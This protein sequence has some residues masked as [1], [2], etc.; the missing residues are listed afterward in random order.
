[1]KEAEGV[2]LKNNTPWLSPGTQTIGIAHL[3]KLI[4]SFYTDSFAGTNIGKEL[5]LTDII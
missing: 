3:Y 1:M 2:W 5:V 4:P